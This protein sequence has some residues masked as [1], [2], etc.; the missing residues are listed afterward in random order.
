[1]TNPAAE[2]QEQAPARDDALYPVSRR[3]AERV[4]RMKTAG[5]P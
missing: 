5:E 2:P 1:M 3:I 4:R